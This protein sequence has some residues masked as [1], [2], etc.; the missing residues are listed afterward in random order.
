MASYGTTTQRRSP[1]SPPPP[2]PDA[3]NSKNS[4]EENFYTFTLSFSWPFNIPSTRESAAVRIIRNLEDFSLYYAVFV[5]TVLFIA[6]IPRRKVSVIYLVAT[7]EVTFLYSLLLRA[8]PDSVLLHRIIDK[9]F[10]FFVMFVITALELILTHAAVHLFVVLAATL[11]IV[12]FHAFLCKRKDVSLHED[13]EMARLVGGKLVD[14]NQ[15]E[16]LV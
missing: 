6:L 11:P 5:W 16:N 14:V 8:Y 2:T 10:V 3:N 15:S 9:R 4:S 13:G 12:V 1:N 7:T